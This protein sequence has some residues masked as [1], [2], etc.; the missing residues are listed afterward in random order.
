MSLQ[1]QNPR[2]LLATLLSHFWIPV[3]CDKGVRGP[4]GPPEFMAAA[5][6]VNR[7]TCP[8]ACSAADQACLV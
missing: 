8:I 3:S 5:F 2:G 1:G 7:E 6:A 4:Q